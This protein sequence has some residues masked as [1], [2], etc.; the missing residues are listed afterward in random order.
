MDYKD[1][2]ICVL[3]K[4]GL[5]EAD[6]DTIMKYDCDT[7]EMRR[8]IINGLSKK[9]NKLSAILLYAD[10]RDI[11]QAIDKSL[12]KY[13]VRQL[14]IMLNVDT[15]L[16]AEHSVFDFCLELESVMGDR[17][18]TLMD[19]DV[20]ISYINGKVAVETLADILGVSIRTVKNKID[21]LK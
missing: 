3:A 21:E 4:L 5:S 9:A 18:S 19:N 8:S 2:A 11:Q 16:F 6:L 12:H 7:H 20:I 14:C 13:N 1:K 15:A 17:I 10:V